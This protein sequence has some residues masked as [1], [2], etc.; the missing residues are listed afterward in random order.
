MR[1][2][3]NIRLLLITLVLLLVCGGAFH[4]LHVWQVDRNVT[5]LL[6]YA[7]EAAKAKKY[8]QAISLYDQYLK[9]VP[10]DF[11]VQEELANHL[12]DLA[13]APR[14]HARVAALYETLLLKSAN[15]P[16]ARQRLI[17]DLILIGR[18]DAAVRHLE[19]LRPTAK[20]PADIEHKRGWCLDAEGKA[21]A[22]AQAFRKAVELDPKRVN[23]WL[24]LAEVLHHR[25]SRDVEAQK[26]L[27]AMIAANPDSA[28]ARL[29]RFRYDRLLG[30]DDDAAK[31]LAEAQRLAPDDADVILV[32]CQWAQSKGDFTKARDLV[33][34]GTKLYPANESMIKELA[35]LELRQGRRDRALEVIEAGIKALGTKTSTGELQIFHADLLIDANRIS[36]A[37]AIIAALRKEGLAPALPDF[38][39]ARILVQQRKWSEAQKLLEKARSTVGSDPYWN[40]RINALLGVCFGQLGDGDRQ[41]AS[42]LDAA[43]T[44]AR[45]PAL[46]FSLG[47]AYLDADNPEQALQ[48]LQPLLGDPESP[49]GLYTLIARARYRL[50]MQ[51]PAKER[52]WKDVDNAV[53][54]AE[55]ADPGSLDLAILR[56]QVLEGQSKFD[57]ARAMLGLEIK[58]RLTQAHPDDLALWI[59]FAALETNTGDY[60][61][62][63][64]ILKDAQ[65]RFGDSAA[66]RL[67]KARMLT[68]RGKIGDRETLKSLAD[69]ANDLS[70]AERGRLDRSLAEIWLRLGDAAAARDLLVKA[71]DD[72]PR[73][74]RSRSLLVDLDLQESKIDDARKWLKEMQTIEGPNGPLSAYAALYVQ[75][76][77]AFG[78]PEVLRKL[79]ADL[80]KSPLRRGDGR[81][82]IVEAR[83]HER[84]GENDLSLAKLLEAAYA[85]QRS[86]RVFQRLVKM[87]TERQEHDQLAW[88][89]AQIEGRGPTPR[90]VGRAAIESALAKGNLEQARELLGPVSLD[91]IRDYRELLWLGR[92]Y[93]TLKDPARAESAYRRAAQVAPHATDAWVAL[94][95]D[96]LANGKRPKAQDLL[97]EIDKKAPAKN[98][99]IITARVLQTLGKA[100]EAEEA[101]RVALQARPNDFLILLAAGDFERQIDQPA[102]AEKAYK[103]ILDPNLATPP[104][105]AARARRGW[106]QA[107]A[108]TPKQAAAV[109]APNR[110][111]N[112]LI[113]ERLNLFLEGLDPTRRADALRDFESTLTRGPLSADESFWLIQLL[114]AAGQ[115][116]A[117]AA[118]IDRLIADGVDTPQ[119]LAF[120]A[121]S[122]LSQGKVEPARI[123]I[124]RLATREPDSTRTRDLQLRVAD[125]K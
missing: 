105:I 102:I 20:D 10:N 37:E 70:P 86:P 62:A 50:T 106:A 89:V 125:K 53:S 57:E 100:K 104:E 74:L 101:Y 83:I 52:L 122:L 32:G 63:D 55:K 19:I 112:E 47:Q 38:L 59:A 13:T 34:K 114:D 77:E 5:S 27:D 58:K 15:R 25:L 72:L 117:A 68:Q 64:D 7:R 11:D 96:L 123:I 67:G 113:D 33:D 87:L 82:E 103:K 107:L 14:D 16:D 42:L 45:W 18:Y 76:E 40:G 8:D 35:S 121:R 29:G 124:A 69:N 90:E 85:G 66:I 49:R 9:M 75:V 28:A 22:A 4:A 46:N 41:L 39:E 6:S 54:L 79:L 31:D 56:A 3:L 30:R 88:V 24:L 120:Q 61:R 94:A 108:A 91:S 1:R 43:R 109:L 92:T 97:A 71:A 84:L 23:S 65:K 73:D 36:D 118:R 119:I 51:Q 116:D 80:K 98:R 93:K 26:A 115:F 81:I 48:Y 2:K 21:D 111:R 60:D 44:E 12:D 95:E 110:G 99:P 17:A 78:Q